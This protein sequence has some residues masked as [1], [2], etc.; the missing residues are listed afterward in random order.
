LRGSAARLAVAALLALWGCG[1]A[2]P[3]PERQSA[4]PSPAA[5]PSGPADTDFALLE[6]EWMDALAR[7]DAAALERLLA[8]EFFITGVGSTAADAVGGRAEWL[9]NAARYPWPRHEIAD[10]RVARLG[11]RGEVAVVKLRLA[12]DY[13]P[14]SLSR[15]GGRLVFLVTDV[16]VWRDD[17]WQV[18]A[19]HSSFP[20]PEEQAAPIGAV[21][22][23]GN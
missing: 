16:W 4:A 23:P 10:V 1:E 22:A 5:A 19:R 9:A 17:R 20:A 13:P 11:E 12:G 15:G 21:E 2:P 3:P 14:Q 7:R 8:P 6:G 18:A